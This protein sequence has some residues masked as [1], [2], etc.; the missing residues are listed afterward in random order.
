MRNKMFSTGENAHLFRDIPYKDLRKFPNATFMPFD[1]DLI[2][3]F[4]VSTQL[5]SIARYCCDFVQVF[6]HSQLDL[7]I[8]QNDG[9]HEKE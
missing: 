4:S 5:A 3:I 1:N 2:P 8:L 9:F 6:L 7:V